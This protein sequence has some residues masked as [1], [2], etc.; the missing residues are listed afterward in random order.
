MK[1]VVL[2]CALALLPVTACFGVCDLAGKM[3]TFNKSARALAHS[4]PER[5][6]EVQPELERLAQIIQGLLRQEGDDP[7]RLDD[8]CAVLDAMQALLD[9]QQTAP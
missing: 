5:L 4:A 9:R 3:E 6:D 8:I 2:A 1:T 7:Q